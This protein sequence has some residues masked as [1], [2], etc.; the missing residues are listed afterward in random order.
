MKKYVKELMNTIKKPEMK[1]LPGNVAFF[2]F[3]SIIPIITLTGFIAAIFSVGT[4]SITEMLMQVLPDS[5]GE[6][7]LPF[8][9]NTGA[10]AN[11]LIFTISGFILASNGPH[12][13]ILAS[14]T[15]YGIE[16]TDYLKRRIKAFFLTILLVVLAIFMI[17]VLA[18][19]NNILKWILSLG[20]LKNIGGTIYSLF[21]LLKWPTALFIIFFLIKLLYTMAPDKRIP[22]KYMNKGAIFVTLTWMIVTAIYSYYVSN[23]SNYD[24]F[25]G[26]LSNIIIFLMWTYI[27]S[28]LLVLGIA[29]NNKEL[30]NTT[31]HIEK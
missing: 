1:I 9:H 7:L 3:L 8:L 15:L 2:L 28:Y 10:D 14:N 26:S 4:D 18:F 19:G 5:I 23:F 27:L 24:I 22:S 17:V 30:T 11:V 29:I 31:T 16:H 13:I 21:I 6:L 12:S 25:Y 20:P